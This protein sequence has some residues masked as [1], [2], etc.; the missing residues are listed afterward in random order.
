MTKIKISVDEVK[1]GIYLDIHG[2]VYEVERKEIVKVATINGIKTHIKIHMLANVGW[3]PWKKTVN[4]AHYAD[5][6]A[7]VTQV[8][9]S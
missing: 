5:H 3:G 1:P 9:R 6:G 8:I 2:D 4:T 7:S